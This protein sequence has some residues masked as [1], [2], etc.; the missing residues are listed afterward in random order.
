MDTK[1]FQVTVDF[2]RARAEGYRTDNID[3]TSLVGAVPSAI[4]LAGDPQIAMQVRI[5]ERDQA[6]LRDAV[7]SLCIVE[8]YSD[9]DLY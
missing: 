8:D 5:A 2:R 1:D 9:L 4:V 6:R 3:I 7:Q